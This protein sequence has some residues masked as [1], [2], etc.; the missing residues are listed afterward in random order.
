MATTKAQVAEAAF[1]F[2]ETK[3]ST[4]MIYKTSLVKTKGIISTY[5][6][7]EEFVFQRQKLIIFRVK[8]L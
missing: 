7:E 3:T 2:L 6:L 1:F 5:L 4:V 8:L